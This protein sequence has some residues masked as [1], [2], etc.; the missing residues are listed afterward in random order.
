M[1]LNRFLDDLLFRR[2]TYA[3]KQVFGGPSLSEGN[4]CV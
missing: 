4:V 3:S 2:E 1:R